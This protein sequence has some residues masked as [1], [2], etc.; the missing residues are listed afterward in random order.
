MEGTTSNF[1]SRVLSNIS[2]PIND[3]GSVR[4][5]EEG[6]VVESFMGWNVPPGPQ[7][8][9]GMHFWV[10]DMFTGEEI[11]AY[12]TND[13]AIET[14]QTGGSTWICKNGM[15]VSGSQ[16]GHWVGYDL[17]NKE[18]AWQSED[19]D[20]PWGA[21]W[22]YNRASYDI[23]SDGDGEGDIPCVITGTYEGIYAIN[24]LNG[25]IEWHYTQPR[26][27]TYEN[28]Y[29]TEAGQ[30]AAP[31][32]TG[33]FTAD[34]KVYAYN[35]EHS[36]SQPYGRD[37]SVHC[38]NADTGEGIWTLYNPMRPRGVAD[39]YLVTDNMYDGYMYT[40]G[41]GKTEL[42]VSGPKEGVPLGTSVVIEGSVL[43]MSPAQP[44]TPCV[45]EDSMSI[46]MEY[47]HLQQ[48]IDGIWHNETITGVEVSLTAMDVNDPTKFWDLGTV[49]SNGYTGK[50]AM[51]WT[52]DEEGFYEI[53]ASFGPTK[54]Y[55]S[56]SDGTY[57]SVGPA[58]AGPQPVEP[59]THPLVTTEVAIILAVVV[60]A[61]I[62]LAAYWLFRKR[63]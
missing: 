8:G 31:F 36:A 6:L 3:L 43:D 44:G 7:W 51:E 27:V 59:E 5:Y 49:T 61:V 47:L 53:Y 46:Q 41:Q 23:D 22:P 60:V 25:D 18:L 35:G 29:Q 9:L 16:G 28:P 40:F 10:Y 57:V 48:P 13:T 1:A 11:W 12:A 34:G 39:G 2:W 15:L 32:F 26:S 52:P 30:P 42:T 56:S 24:I 20:Y 33:V 63:Q 37:W 38:I 21:W 4:D 45:S 54:A 14:T 50:F 17:R 58:P 19:T 62:G 55:G